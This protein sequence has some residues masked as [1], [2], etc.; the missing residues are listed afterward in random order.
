MTMN[1]ARPAGWIALAFIG[2]AAALLGG[3]TSFLTEGTS[4]GAGIA[5]AGISRSVTHNAGVTTGIGLGVQ[6][7]ARAGL[8]YT[9]RKV[10]QAEQDQI[11]A[12]A[13]TLPVG[14]V[15]HWQIVHGIPIEADEQGEVVVSRMLGGSGLAC[16]EIVFSVDHIEK[17]GTTREFYTA[18]VCRDGQQWKWATA[19]PATERWGAL[20]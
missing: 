8:Q 6:A 16:K 1:A 4:A 11:A 13:G 3:C 10:H 17:S 9:E 15:A 19:E 7:A 5:A 14:G 18:T 2:A 12:T 20:Q